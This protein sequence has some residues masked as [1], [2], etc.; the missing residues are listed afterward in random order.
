MYTAYCRAV[1]GKAFNGDLLPSWQVFRAD[2]AKKLQSDAW[3]EA[4]QVAFRVFTGSD[5]K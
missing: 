1:G 2:P 3:L 4:A 5:S